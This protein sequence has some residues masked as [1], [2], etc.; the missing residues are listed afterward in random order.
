MV[1]ISFRPDLNFDIFDALG[2]DSTYYNTTE[3]DIHTAWIDVS[4]H[5]HP[6]QIQANRPHVPKFQLSIKLSELIDF[7]LA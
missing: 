4:G 5:L 3:S 7:S 2:L 1:D 6:D